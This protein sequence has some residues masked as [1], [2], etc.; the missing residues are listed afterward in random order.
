M[1]ADGLDEVHDLSRLERSMNIDDGLKNLLQILLLDHEVNL[2]L[3]FIALHAAVDKSK[4]LR[5]DFVEQETAE[6]RL[7]CIL[8]NGAVRHL[9]LHTDMNAALQC[10]F[11]VL[12][13]EDSLVEIVIIIAGS[14]YTLSL[15]GK[16]I[17]TKDHIL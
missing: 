5:N 1:I 3:E 14:L 10:A 4:I 17:D 15:L 9:L 2:E 13:S 8:Q 12:I 16:I 6:C 7:D 11:T